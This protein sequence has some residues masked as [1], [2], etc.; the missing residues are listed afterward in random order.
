M[1]QVFDGRTADEIWRLA[2]NG[3]IHSQAGRQQ[4]SRLGPMREYLHCSLHLSDPRQRWVLSRRP[5]MN[6]AF[7]IA[8]LIWILLGR[9]DAGFVNYWN[10]A[11]PHFAGHTD[12]Y[13][14]A[15]GYRLR[16]HF[17]IDQL[18]RAYQALTANPDS[19]QVVLQIWDTQKDLPNPD[20]TSR[21]ADIPCN[22]VAMPK[23]RDGKLEW[24]Q[25]MRSNDLFLGT[26]HN[27]IQFTSLQEI[28]AGWLEVD[29]GSFVLVSDSLHYYEHDV[30]K[31]SIAEDVPEMV[32]R[33]CLNLPK[34][35][36][37]R[38][39]PLIGAAM[40]EFRADNL[41]RAR[42]VEL[43][44]RTELPHAWKNLLTVV[45]ADVARRR[46]WSDEMELASS[47]CSNAMLVTAWNAWEHRC[48]FA[49]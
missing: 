35:E 1:I 11:L 39:L 38:T 31:L 9:N 36:F 5:A 10:P 49:S 19:R 47:R 13:H 16:N 25:V 7:A 26:P 21:D 32:N 18:E 44:D 20:G 4:G 17:A 15:Y 3:L 33:D 40:N 41:S 42:F 8:E 27:F 23:I 6:P 12:T 14:G 46:A 48:R 22:I 45:A 28:I 37:D 43:I 30:E 29:L 2:T 34:A 24:L